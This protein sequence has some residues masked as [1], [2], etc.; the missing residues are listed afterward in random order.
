MSVIV[1]DLSNGT[2]HCYTKGADVVIVKRMTDESQ[3]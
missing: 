1:K 2:F 3:K